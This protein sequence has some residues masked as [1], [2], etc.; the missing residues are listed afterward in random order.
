MMY[1]L[2]NK[3]D[4]EIVDVIAPTLEEAKEHASLLL[5]GK[6][7][8]YEERFKEKEYICYETGQTMTQKDWFLYYL[9]SEEID[10]TE[11]K[12]FSEWW[13][14]MTVKSHVLEVYN[15]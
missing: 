15:G 9:Q 5:D 12:D 3:T 13:Q 6:E 4:G 1:H 14:D 11:Y 2:I 10:K 8:D 7:S